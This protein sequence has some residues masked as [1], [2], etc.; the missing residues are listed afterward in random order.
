MPKEAVFTV[1]L[2]SELRDAFLAEAEA[3]HRP[4]SQLVRDFM[5]DFVRQRTEAREHDT[6]FRAQ[7]QEALDSP[8]AGIPHDV[9]RDETRAIIDRIA[10]AKAK[11]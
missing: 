3:T 7:V 11:A 1:K 9:V 10:A 2:E 5:R 8:L 6:W 4:A